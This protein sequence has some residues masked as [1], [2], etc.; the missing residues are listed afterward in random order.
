M[1]QTTLIFS[2]WYKREGLERINLLKPKATLPDDC[3]NYIKALNPKETLFDKFKN[4]IKRLKKD[5]KSNKH[6][7]N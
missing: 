4:Y 7:I 5:D 2:S 1:Y 6:G 3:K